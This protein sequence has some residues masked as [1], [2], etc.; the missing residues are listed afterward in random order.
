MQ[1][2]DNESFYMTFLRGTVGILSLD[3]LELC[4]EWGTGGDSAGGDSGD[5]H[6]SK[7]EI[8]ASATTAESGS[9]AGVPGNNGRGD[10]KGAS[11]EEGPPLL[12]E[13]QWQRLRTTLEDQVHSICVLAQA[14]M[15]KELFFFFILDGL[16][17]K[18][19]T[20]RTATKDPGVSLF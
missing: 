17:A 4:P 7:G 15:D 11:S 20:Y 12:G 1:V 8:G 5:A 16:R 13:A 10:G 3:A 9:E 2:G 19:C 6:T 14:G 18:W